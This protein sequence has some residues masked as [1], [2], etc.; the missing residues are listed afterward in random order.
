MNTD[1]PMHKK[2]QAH[3]VLTQQLVGMAHT[4]TE[5]NTKEKNALAL[6]A[7]WLPGQEKNENLVW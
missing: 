1:K 7:L 6:H 3:L 4:D 5:S 2:N